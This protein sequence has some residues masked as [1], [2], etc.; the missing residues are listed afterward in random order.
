MVNTL[1]P[2]VIALAYTVPHVNLHATSN[3]PLTC[4]KTNPSLIIIA[5]AHGGEDPHG[6]DPHGDDPHDEYHDKGLPANE[7]KKHW[8]A[9][10]DAY[11]GEAPNT[12]EPYNPY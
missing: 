9:P 12:K 6:D 5:D 7:E 8:K 11:G 3:D 1:L 10:K 2:I 4:L